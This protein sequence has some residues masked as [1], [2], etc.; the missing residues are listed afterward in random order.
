[1]NDL[2][3]VCLIYMSLCLKRREIFIYIPIHI[4]LVLLSRI[5]RLSKRSRFELECI[6]I[7][8]WE[9]GRYELFS[10]D[11]L[12]QFYVIK[13]SLK[14]RVARGLKHFTIKR[15]RTFNSF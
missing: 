6:I 5:G 9:I 11:W 13:N 8:S 12:G 3:T 4:L 1:M 15:L 7:I 14:V 10:S 2:N